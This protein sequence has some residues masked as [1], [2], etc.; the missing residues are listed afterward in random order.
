MLA[1]GIPAAGS[2]PGSRHL[3]RQLAIKVHHVGGRT[4]GEGSYQISGTNR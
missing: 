3:P 1:D 4:E 2:P